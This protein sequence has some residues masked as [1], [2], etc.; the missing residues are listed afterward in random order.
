MDKRRHDEDEADCQA[1]CVTIIPRDTNI[2]PRT[3]AV[4]ADKDRRTGPEVARARRVGEGGVNFLATSSSSFTCL[5]NLV[6]RRNHLLSNSLKR[7][8]Q[9][10]I[11]LK[12]IPTSHSTVFA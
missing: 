10:N 4:R 5:L 7:V 11:V 1:R 3:N 6:I 8:V 2:R 9:L 12:I